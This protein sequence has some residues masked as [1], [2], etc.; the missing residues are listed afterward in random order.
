[1]LKKISALTCICL[2][3]IY[4]IASAFQF[5]DYQWGQSFDEVVKKLENKG[6]VLSYTDYGVAY[7]DNILDNP[8]YVFLAFTPQ[9]KELAYISI[10]WD[11]TSLGET[12][13]ASFKEKFKE[14]LVISE[15]TYLWMGPDQN[16][17]DSIYLN[18]KVSGVRLFYFGGKYYEKFN[19]EKIEAA[20]ATLET[21]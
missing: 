7:N 8:C 12:L 1:M 19:E 20:K 4:S 13:R 18:Y 6:R 9:T 10:A 11:E 2:S 14:P 21:K 16:V 15:D 3:L 5:E 17:F